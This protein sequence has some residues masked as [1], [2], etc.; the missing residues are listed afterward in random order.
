[1]VSV[2][3]V[4]SVFIR[5]DVSIVG[6]YPYHISMKRFD[7]KKVMEW[8]GFILR[9]PICGY[10]YSTDNTKVIDSEEDDV[11]GEAKIL[12][13]SDCHKCKS[14]IMFNIEIRGPEVFS[15]GMVTDLTQKDSAKFQDKDPIHADEIIAIHQTLKKFNGDFVK[16]LGTK[17]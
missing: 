3:S 17:K 16:V 11:M 7:L 6:I 5:P 2:L 12:I 14:S 8:L 13:H 9:C 4:P 1:M 10:K 15:V